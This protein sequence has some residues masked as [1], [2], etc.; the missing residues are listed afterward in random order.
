M[1][2]F[3]L[4]E[5]FF[6][7]PGFPSMAWHMVKEALDKFYPAN[8]QKY[9]FSLLADTSEHTLM[10]LMLTLPQELEFSSLPIIQGDKR[11]VT[12]SIASY[13]KKE[14]QK[15][16]DMFVIYLKEHNINYKMVDE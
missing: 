4:Q 14:A 13:D 7:V 12:I 9:R 8:Q 6:F 1:P 11:Q 5:R 2:G 16:F 15:Y 10:D 3:Y